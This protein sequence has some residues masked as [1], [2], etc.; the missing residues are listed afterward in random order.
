VNNLIITYLTNKL[1]TNI[2]REYDIS[3]EDYSYK[4]TQPQVN[5]VNILTKTNR[6]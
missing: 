5:A 6:A 2:S 3:D 4:V 1:K